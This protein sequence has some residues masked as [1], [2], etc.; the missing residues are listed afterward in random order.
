MSEAPRKSLL[1]KRA[2]RLAAAQALYSEALIEQKTLPALLVAQVLQSWADSR[3]NQAH[4]LPNVIQP[5]QALLNAIVAAAQE[6]AVRIEAVIDTMILPNWK[7]S[8]MSLPLLS[9][10]RACAAEALAY[11]SRNRATLVEEYTEVAA[12]ITTDEEITYAHKAF[13]LLLDALL[14]GRTERE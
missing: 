5:E 14:P 1:R 11:P 4:D 6:H 12:Q 2:S 3:A 9:T 8:R 7:K 10:L 13:N